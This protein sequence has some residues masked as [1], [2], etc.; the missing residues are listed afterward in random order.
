[1]K[2]TGY[3][4]KRMMPG[5][6]LYSTLLQDFARALLNSKDTDEIFMRKMKIIEIIWNYSIAKKYKMPVFEELN[7]II[8]AQNKT[9]PATKEV[10]NMF[11]KLKKREYNQYNNYILKT[12]LRKNQEGIKT[13]YVE[14]VEVSKN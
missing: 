7:R 13:L 11:L 12:E 3:K 9:S 5:K 10:F 6:V 4:S 1:M 14:S 2:Y 8:A